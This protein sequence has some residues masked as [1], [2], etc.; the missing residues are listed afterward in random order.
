MNDMIDWWIDMLLVSR[1]ELVEEY[2]VEVFH[3]YGVH[4]PYSFLM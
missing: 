1:F 2:D 4:L 3:H